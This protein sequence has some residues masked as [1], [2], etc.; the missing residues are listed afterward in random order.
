[1]VEAGSDQVDADTRGGGEPLSG[2]VAPT[3]P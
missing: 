3:A 1:V 2:Y